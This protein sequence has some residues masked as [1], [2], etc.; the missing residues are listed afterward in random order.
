M[1]VPHFLFASPQQPR[2]I[3]VHA[4]YLAYKLIP[5]IAVQTSCPAS[6]LEKKL[7][8]CCGRKCNLRVNSPP[9]VEKGFRF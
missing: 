1:P 7:T 9:A 8:Q 2:W 5:G 4:D 3:S 6:H